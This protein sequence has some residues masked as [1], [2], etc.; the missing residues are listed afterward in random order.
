[1]IEETVA[2]L[3]DYVNDC[4]ENSKSGNEARE[5]ADALEATIEDTQLYF[6]CP[7]GRDDCEIPTSPDPMP[8]CEVGAHIA[9]LRKMYLRQGYFSNARQ[10][11]IAPSELCFKLVPYEEEPE[12]VA[13]GEDAEEWQ[14]RTDREGG[15][16]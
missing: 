13:D 4:E 11:R 3:R 7:D 12:R 6:V 8:L 16:G 5:L 9:I 1:M 10:E 14:K 15:R 2:W